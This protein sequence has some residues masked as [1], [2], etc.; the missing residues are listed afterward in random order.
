VL[1]GTVSTLTRMYAG[2]DEGPYN[3]K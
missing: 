3:T 1:I 2:I